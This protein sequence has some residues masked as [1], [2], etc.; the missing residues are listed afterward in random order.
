MTLSCCSDR[1]LYPTLWDWLDPSLCPCPASCRLSAACLC[2]NPLQAN[3]S[4]TARLW[5]TLQAGCDLLHPSLFDSAAL[6]LEPHLMAGPSGSA[7]GPSGRIGTH[8]ADLVSPSLGVL[9]AL[10]LGHHPAA[11]P[12]ILI[13]AAGL[14]APNFWSSAAL[15]PGR[16]HVSCCPSAAYPCLEQ[17]AVLPS[18]HTRL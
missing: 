9:A 15:C 16:H 6:C 2:L 11:G 12:A 17:Q 5:T 7:A 10:C 14:L 4:A 1:E 3:L 18:S 13:Q 8:V